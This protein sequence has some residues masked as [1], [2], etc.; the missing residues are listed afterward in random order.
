MVFSSVCRVFSMPACSYE[1]LKHLNTS[2]ERVELVVEVVGGKGRGKDG[3]VS[4][5][6]GVHGVYPLVEG[7]NT[8]HTSMNGRTAVFIAIGGAA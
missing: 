4:A 7:R 2:P 8:S 5:A 6:L 1:H 3:S